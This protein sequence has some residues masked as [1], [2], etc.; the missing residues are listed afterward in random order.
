ML[1]TALLSL[2]EVMFQVP[3]PWGDLIG[4]PLAGLSMVALPCWAAVRLREPVGKTPRASVAACGV[5]AGLFAAVNA[6]TVTFAL[7]LFPALVR[8]SLLNFVCFR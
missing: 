6:V 8:R 4:Y 2:T 1:N 5:A 3:G 7:I